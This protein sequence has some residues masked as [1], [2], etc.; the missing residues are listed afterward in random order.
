MGESK[1]KKTAVTNPIKTAS[2]DMRTKS[3]IQG[4]PVQEVTYGKKSIMYSLIGVGLIAIGMVLMSGGWMPSP[5]VW[6]ESIIY[7]ARRMVLAPIFII[8]GLVMQVM[9]IFKV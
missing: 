3:T 8:A 6:D 9:A 2:P 7:S 5:D 1:S 4:K